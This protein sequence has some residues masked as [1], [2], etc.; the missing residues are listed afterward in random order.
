[1]T[2]EK[3]FSAESFDVYGYPVSGFDRSDF[4]AYL[5][6]DPYHFVPDGYSGFCAWHAAVF[7]VQV[8][9]ADAAEGY[10]YDCI[11]GVFYF[12][13]RF[14][15]QF[16]FSVFNVCVGKHGVFSVDLRVVFSGKG[17]DFLEGM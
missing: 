15:P 17:N 12:R 11:F 1:M 14:F 4:G 13:F 10:A 7:D 8:A 2:A 6:Y 5:F 16:K 9:G 3:T